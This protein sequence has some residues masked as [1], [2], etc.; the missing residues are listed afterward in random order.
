MLAQY[1]SAYSDV[2]AEIEKSTG[3]KPDPSKELETQV[4][5]SLFEKVVGC[6]DEN[7]LDFIAELMSG[8]IIGQALPNANHRTAIYWVSGI[9]DNVGFKVNLI[10]NAGLIREY[11]L[12]SKHLLKKARKGYESQHLM[13]T[14]RT[15]IALLGKDQSGKLGRMVAYSF[16]TALSDLAIDL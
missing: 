5:L 4:L 14:K 6:P 2:V 9:L 10:E 13:L 12:D 16:I 1:L 11:F 8:L 15:V 7:G 3:K